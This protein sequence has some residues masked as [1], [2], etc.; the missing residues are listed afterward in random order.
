MRWAW[1]IVGFGIFTAMHASRTQ[2]PSRSAAQVTPQVVMNIAQSYTPPPMP[3]AYEHW[4]MPVYPS[5]HYSSRDR[6]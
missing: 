4:S 1:M 3:R 2:S 6:D 5:Q